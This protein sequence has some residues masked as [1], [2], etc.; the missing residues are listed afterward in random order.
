MWVN[1]DIQAVL[2]SDT[3]HVVRAALSDKGGGK[4]EGRYTVPEGTEV[5]ADD[6]GIDIKKIPRMKKIWSS[7]LG[8]IC[9]K[10]ADR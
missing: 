10:P 9:R 5:P 6:M 4:Y 8:T 2:R 7:P 1:R 3:G